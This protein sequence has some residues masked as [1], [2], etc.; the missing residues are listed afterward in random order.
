MASQ[1]DGYLSGLRRFLAFLGS[2]WGIL[3][4]ISVFFPMS[5]QLLDGGIPLESWD[6]GALAFL[7]PEWIT[8]VTTLVAVVV[9]FW[10]YTQRRAFRSRAGRARRSAAASFVLGFAALILYLVLYTLLQDDFHYRVLGWESD[11]LRRVLFDLAL[12]VLYCGF[13]ALLT[14]GFVLMAGLEYFRAHRRI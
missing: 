8:T 7:A 12:L 2:L 14:R 5:N 3:G 11:D 13:F 6:P 4:G 9:I 1:S 10:T